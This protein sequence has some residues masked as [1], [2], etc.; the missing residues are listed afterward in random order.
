MIQRN[1]DMIQRRKNMKMT[2]DI[3]VKMG[4]SSDDGPA[5]FKEGRL[6]FNLTKKEIYLDW[7]G[8]R[9]VFGQKTTCDPQWIYDDEED[10]D[11]EEDEPDY[12]PEPDEKEQDAPALPPDFLTMFDALVKIQEA[13]LRAG[14]GSYFG[15]SIYAKGK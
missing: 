9:H 13:R 15:P 8:Q 10:D 1:T 14:N 3:K 7:K 5:D 11:I 6:S 2:T 4:V 12:R